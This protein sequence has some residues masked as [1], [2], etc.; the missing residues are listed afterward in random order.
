MP[1]SPEKRR[2]QDRLYREAH[3]EQ[4]RASDREYYLAHR[5]NRR[6]R[7]TTP[8]ARERM[9]AYSKRRREDPEI[10][11]ADLARVH[12]F[13]QAD[14]DR[15]AALFAANKANKRAA[16]VGIPGRLSYHDV[17][18]VWARD[19]RCVGCGEGRGLDHIVP[20][21]RGGANEQA[22]LQ[23]LCKTCNN[24]KGRLIGVG[25]PDAPPMAAC[26]RCG[27]RV[28]TRRSRFCSKRCWSQYRL[29]NF[30][31]WGHR[32]AA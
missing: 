24:R 1:R 14:P 3:R 16:T 2:E 31:Q 5:G 10:R 13:Q 19:P 17:L 6:K 30:G 20:Y 7:P 4:R 22:N 29:A 21:S 18:A 25:I 12:A 28:K 15:K 23:N 8:E 9:R 27:G 32:K 11:A 26:Q